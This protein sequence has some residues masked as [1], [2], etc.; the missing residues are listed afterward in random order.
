LSI[1]SYLFLS[2]GLATDQSLSLSGMDLENIPAKVFEIENLLS[3]DLSSN[4]IRE[5]PTELSYCSS[6]EVRTMLFAA[7]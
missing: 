4:H 5:L 2:N 1:Y 3:L 6:L 7:L